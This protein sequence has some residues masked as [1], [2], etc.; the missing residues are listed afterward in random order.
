MYFGMSKALSS[1]GYTQREK[2]MNN[3]KKGSN[4][5]DGQDTAILRTKIKKEGEK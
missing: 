4:L 3:D 1:G 5:S 2:R